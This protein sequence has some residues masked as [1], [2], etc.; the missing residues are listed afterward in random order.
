MTTY[1]LELIQKPGFFVC[2]PVSLG[3]ATV[4]TFDTPD[5]AEAY[6]WSCDAL[7]VMGTKVS[8]T[9]MVSM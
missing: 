7:L 2:N 3:A 1:A 6:R 9:N 4:L 5:A 8:C